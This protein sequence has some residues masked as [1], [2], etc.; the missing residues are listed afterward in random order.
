ML[1]QNGNDIIMPL[2]Y[3]C[4][5]PA[6]CKINVYTDGSWLFPVQKFLGLGGA[7]VWW[8]GRALT[9]NQQGQAVRPLS[10]EEKEMA[11]YTTDNDGVRLH[12]SI[13]GF[14]GSSTRTELAAGIIAI[15]ALGPVHIGSDSEVFFKG[16]NHHIDCIKNIKQQHTNW[17]LT[18]DG[19]LWEHFYEA[20]RVKGANSVRVNWVKGHATKEH[21]DKGITTETDKCG[22]HEADAQADIGAAL[23][24]EDLIKVAECMQGRHTTYKYLMRDVSQHILDTS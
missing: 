2:P 5:A 19:D 17:K 20:V 8:P 4:I 7:G 18:S 22:N 13:G 1:K 9:S 11:Q 3:Q 21:I 24:G 12:T 14:S 6:P 16:A 10:H 23:H 15:C